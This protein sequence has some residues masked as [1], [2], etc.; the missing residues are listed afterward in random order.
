VLL[1]Q[2]VQCSQC[3]DDGQAGLTQDQFWEMTA[4]FRQLD[5][6]GYGRG[7]ARLSR[8]DSPEPVRF[9]RPD[10]NWQEVEPRFFADHDSGS[11]SEPDDRRAELARL[12]TESDLFARA[13]VNRIW[14]HLLGY[15]FTSPVDDMGHRNPASHPALLDEVADQFAKSEF[16]TQRLIRWIVLSEPFNRSEVLA[17]G[18][19]SDIPEIS[20]VALFSRY[21]HRSSLF[22]TPHDALVSLGDG[23]ADRLA[24]MLSESILG[25]KQDSFNEDD[26]KA[27]SDDGNA[28]VDMASQLNIGQLRLARS[29]AKS[30]MSSDEKLRHLFLA[31]MARFPS[32]AEMRQASRLYEAAENDEIQAMEHLIWALTRTQEFIGR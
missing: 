13:A 15:G 6:T 32:E 4:F 21:Y 10:G 14:A 25:R 24:S 12:I 7:R 17:V 20:F 18:N 19:K 1:G 3:H 5:F 2:R 22:P 11:P 23:K 30:R 9:Q 27:D 26:S 31:V 28:Q 29:L 16:D 8:R